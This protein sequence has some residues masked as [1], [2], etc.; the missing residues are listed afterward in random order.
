M[1]PALVW[2]LINDFTFQTIHYKI[3]STEEKTTKCI[4]T[5]IIIKRFNAN[6]KM[7]YNEHGGRYQFFRRETK[8]LARKLAIAFVLP[9]LISAEN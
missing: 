7:K 2:F 9:E 1:V 4:N 8:R 5:K 6:F 3:F